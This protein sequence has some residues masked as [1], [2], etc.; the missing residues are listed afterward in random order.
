[1]G[2]L[3]IYF[4]GI[5]LVLKQ[6]IYLA[7]FAVISSLLLWFFIYIPVRNVPGNDFAFQLTLFKPQDFLLLI[8]LALLTSLSINMNVY[9][10]RQRATVSTGVSAISQGGVGGFA[11]I[12]ASIFGTATCST[13]VASL[14][15]FL[16]IGTVFFLLDNKNYI[17]LAS[18]LLVLFSLYFTSKKVLHVCE[19]C[20]HIKLKG[21]SHKKP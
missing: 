18:I 19:E 6:R 11:G 17:V 5:K 13:C 21:Y 12:I 3:T 7:S 4:E 9:S 15:G 8:T 14:F 2:K 1:M 16:G 20:N 10:F